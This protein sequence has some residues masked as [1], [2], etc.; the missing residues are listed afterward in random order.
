LIR[1]EWNT[2]DNNRRARYY[3]LTRAGRKH[4]DDELASWRRMSR[5]INLVLEAR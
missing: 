4:F 3:A 5:A 1:S 2:T